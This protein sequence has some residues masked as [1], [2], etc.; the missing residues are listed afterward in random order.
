MWAILALLAQPEEPI[1]R[2]RVLAL[3]EKLPDSRAELVKLGPGA[4]RL[5][6]EKRSA[7]VEKG[8]FELNCPVLPADVRDKLAADVAMRTSPIPLAE[9]DERCG[10]FLGLPIV[11]DLGLD[12]DRR[13]R[14]VT[15]KPG[16]LDAV[17]RAAL[18]D[19]G[20]DYA[21]V[22]G[23]IVISTPERLWSYPVPADRVLDAE[24][25]G[26]VR[27]WISRVG[28]ND[29]FVALRE[30]GRAAVPYLEEELRI[31]SFESDRR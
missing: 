29:A 2:E 3:V 27:Q 5:L 23:R 9:I 7:V 24:E 18:A 1:T 15:L 14:N 28:E 13:T 17:L 11:V 8:M 10:M 26:R 4:L 12:Q 20:L 16:R 31:G 21:V 30:T 22:R 25:T 6:A 19:S